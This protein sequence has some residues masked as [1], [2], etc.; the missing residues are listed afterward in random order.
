MIAD[1]LK[2]AEQLDEFGKDHS[3]TAVVLR[4]DSPGGGVA[5]SQEIYDAILELKKQRKL[6]FPWDRLQ[7]PA[8]CLSRAQPIKLSPIPAP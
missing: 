8:G 4:V 5:T 3:I 1:S 7:R 2:I 6:S